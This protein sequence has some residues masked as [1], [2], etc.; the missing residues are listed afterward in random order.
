MAYSYFRKR[1][2]KKFRPFFK[3]YGRR[4]RALSYNRRGY[5]KNNLS[6]TVNEFS[7]ISHPSNIPTHVTSRIRASFTT[8]Y[9]NVTEAAPAGARLIRGNFPISPSVF[10]PGYRPNNINRYTDYY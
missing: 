2:I 6:R 9:P 1:M 8:T 4:S 3:K 5:F 7:R 10:Q